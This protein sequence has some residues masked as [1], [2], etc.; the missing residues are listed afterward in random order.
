MLISGCM[1]VRAWTVKTGN[2]CGDGILQCEEGVVDV[3]Y[4]CVDGGLRRVDDWGLG[5]NI[6]IVALGLKGV[7]IR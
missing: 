5:T 3:S 1:N 6:R 7:V 2:L 4:W